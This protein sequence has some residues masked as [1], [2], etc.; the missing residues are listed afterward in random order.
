MIS[1]LICFYFDPTRKL[2]QKLKKRECDAQKNLIFA[3]KT[4]R[5]YN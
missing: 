3:N 5:G 4:R 1:I 2:K